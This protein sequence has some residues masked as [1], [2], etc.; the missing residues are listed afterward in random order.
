MLNRARQEGLLRTIKYYLKLGFVVTFVYLYLLFS[1]SST[2]DSNRYIPKAKRGQW[3]DKMIDAVSK[4]AY[5]AGSRIMQAADWLMKPSDGRKV[6]EYVRIQRLK[7][8]TI[9][10]RRSALK[11]RIMMSFLAMSVVASQSADGV[12]AERQVRFDTDS[13][14]IGIDNRCSKCIYPDP[15]DFI[16]KVENTNRTI[17][18]FGG[19]KVTGIKRGGTIRWHWEDDTGQVN[20]FDIPGSYYVPNA[21]QRLLSPQHVAQVMKK[22]T[23]SRGLICENDASVC[24]LQWNEGENTRMVP[25]DRFNNCF[26]FRLAPGFKYFMAYCAKFDLDTGKNN[27]KSAIAEATLIED[28]EDEVKKV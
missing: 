10:I 6:R 4:V 12:N 11:G 21:R 17:T 19:L 24:Q 9:K 23:S 2:N 26:T 1:S 28:D 5:S 15:L 18:Q 13:H 16:G 22:G 25:I 7:H 14:S 8:S 20:Q 27:T 3:G